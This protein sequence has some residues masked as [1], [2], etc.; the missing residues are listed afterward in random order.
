MD[1]WV[2]VSDGLFLFLFCRH[3]Q[4]VDSKVLNIV[5]S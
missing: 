5:Q 1:G 3:G 4:M 2:E